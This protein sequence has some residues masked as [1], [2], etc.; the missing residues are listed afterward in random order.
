MIKEKNVLDSIIYEC[1]CRTA[2]PQFGYAGTLIELKQRCDY[3]EWVVYNLIAH[4]Q[5]VLMSIL[6]CLESHLT[7]FYQSNQQMLHIP[8]IEGF[9]FT[10]IA[11]PPL[12]QEYLHAQ[13][14]YNNNNFGVDG[15]CTLRVLDVDI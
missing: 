10:P 5:G 9:G 12:L 14:N 2:D 15:I 3:L 6:A 1:K 4:N 8:N 13:N 11:F 7:D